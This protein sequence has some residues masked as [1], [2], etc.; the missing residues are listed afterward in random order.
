MKSGLRGILF[1]RLSVGPD[2]GCEQAGHATRFPSAFGVSF[3]GYS[4]GNNVNCHL[5][6]L[7]L[8]CGEIVS[9]IIRSLISDHTHISLNDSIK[10]K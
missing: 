9:S 1:L 7:F 3:E 2:L 5:L 4:E 6:Y 8:L 10:I